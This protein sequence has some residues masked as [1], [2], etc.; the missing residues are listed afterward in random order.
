MLRSC[1]FCGNEF[2]TEADPYIVIPTK[3]H[4][5]SCGCKIGLFHQHNK[6]KTVSSLLRELLLYVKINHDNPKD[7]GEI[8]MQILKE[9]EIKND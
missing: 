1:D 2:L 3:D 9:L 6:A 8:V 7:Y 5:L 4:A